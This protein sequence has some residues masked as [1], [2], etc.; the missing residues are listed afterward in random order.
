MSYLHSH[1][2]LN[3]R[4]IALAAIQ[5]GEVKGFSPF[6]EA[7]LAFLT[8]WLSGQSEF[9]LQTSGST[10]QPK[11]IAVTREQFIASAKATLQALALRE[12]STALIC[13]P[14]QYIAGI[15][16]VVRCLVGNLT[17]T[18]VE[19]A[20]NPLRH[21]SP[22]IEFDFAAMVPLQVSELLANGGIESIQRIKNLLIGGAPLAVV[23]QE[24]LV[25]AN[26]SIY[27]TYGMTETLSH[28]ALQK[29]SGSLSQHYF[30]ALP[31]IELSQDER[32]CLLIRVPYLKEIIKTNDLIE[33]IGPN[34][35]RWLGRWDHVINSGGIKLFPEKIEEAIYKAFQHMGLSYHFFVAGIPHEK[36]GT[37]AMLMIESTTRVEEE[38]LRDLLRNS[39][40]PV[41]IPKQI[42]Y[43][44]SFEFTPTGKV[45]RAET[46]RKLAL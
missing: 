25:E 38:I 19:P 39:L 13:L 4:N 21:L 46:L 23:T 29:I 9:S 24:K 34:T 40:K 17:M 36:L 35:F 30:E 15:M 44:K 33:F 5:K 10:G 11:K 26:S 16:M 22:S 12:N 31:S 37:Q 1:L 14:T 43:L 7:T 8:N 32:G 45:K 2:T 27:L 41:E 42:F 18:I 3:N 28:V 6:E 20:G